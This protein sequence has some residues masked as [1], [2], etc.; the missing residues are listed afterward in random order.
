MSGAPSWS[1]SRPGSPRLEESRRELAHLTRAF[2][3][4]S[5]RDAGPAGSLNSMPKRRSSQ[6]PGHWHGTH[7]ILTMSCHVR[8]IAAS[9][10][11]MSAAATQSSWF[12]DAPDCHERK[13]RQQIRCRFRTARNAPLPPRSSRWR[14]P[15]LA[16]LGSLVSHR[17]VGSRM[18]ETSHQFFGRCALPGGKRGGHTSKPVKG[19]ALQAEGRDG[20]PPN[21]STEIG[22]GQDAASRSHE[23]QTVRPWL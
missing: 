20:R 5:S 21:I 18:T 8:D 10:P 3:A 12:L 17:H 16:S 11:A 4:A 19:E 2:K 1:R 7:R 15:D 9:T 22:R 14:A 23:D 13:V 6:S